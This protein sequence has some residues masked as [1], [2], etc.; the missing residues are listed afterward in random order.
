MTGK[1]KLSNLSKMLLGTS[2]GMRRLGIMDPATHEKIVR[3]I[4]GKPLS[5]QSAAKL[6]A[7]KRGK[8]T[9]S[10]SGAI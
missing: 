1:K 2:A 7:R 9:R 10:N 5:P 6:E 3:R 4:S 8:S